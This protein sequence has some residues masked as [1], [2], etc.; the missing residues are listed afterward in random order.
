MEG[1]FRAGRSPWPVGETA[2]AIRFGPSRISRGDARPAWESYRHTLRRR[3][4]LSPRF[5]SVRAVV[6]RR[7]W[8][9]GCVETPITCANTTSI[10]PRV[11]DSR[12][13]FPPACPPRAA[14][15]AGCELP[16]LLARCQ[17][18]RDA[19][20]RKAGTL[21]PKGFPTGLAISEP[22]RQ[23]SER[24]GLIEAG[25][26]VAQAVAAP[27]LGL[28]IA[29]RARGVLRANQVCQTGPVARRSAAV[30]HGPGEPINL[31]FHRFGRSRRHGRQRGSKSDRL[32]GFELAR[33]VWNSLGRQPS[34]TPTTR[35][36]EGPGGSK[37]SQTR[38]GPNLSSGTPHRM[39]APCRAGSTGEGDPLANCRRGRNSKSYNGLNR[40]RTRLVVAPRG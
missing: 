26:F 28:A 16:R 7:A 5:A 14:A 15:G 37:A 34:G 40:G 1:T 21:P 25:T 31:K 23:A 36:P 12:T 11:R 39:Q 24:Q 20:P 8:W 35:H 33:H 29:A 30:Q 17:G 27:L 38:R 22:R 32:Q 19:P 2:R 4:S 10:A 6:P 9:E 13:P 3:S 18:P